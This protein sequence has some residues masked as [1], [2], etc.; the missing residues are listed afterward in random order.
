VRPEDHL[1]LKSDVLL[2][3]L[4]L[5]DRPLHGYAIIRDVEARSAGQVRLQTGAL[6]R[7][8]RRL[9]QD[10]FISERPAPRGADSSD[11]RRRYYEP[12]RLGRGVLDAELARMARLV[13]AA[14]RR[15]PRLA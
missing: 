10:G 9:L 14:A 1:P 3:L 2:I 15:K 5:A 11:E 6:Y 4:A 8:L 7:T 13:R 12:T